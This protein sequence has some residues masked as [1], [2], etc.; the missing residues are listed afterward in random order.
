VAF[1]VPSDVWNSLLNSGN[2]I[3]RAPYYGYSRQLNTVEYQLNAV[4]MN[5]I[6]PYRRLD[7]RP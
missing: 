1:D 7:W 6:N 2:A 3:L 5:T 4:A